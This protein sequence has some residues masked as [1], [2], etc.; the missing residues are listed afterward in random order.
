MRLNFYD[1]L[2]FLI[3]SYYKRNFGKKELPV[4]TSMIVLGATTFLQLIIL[5]LIA[6]LFYKNDQEYIFRTLGRSDVIFCVILFIAV[7]QLLYFCVNRRYRLII[8]RLRSKNAMYSNSLFYQ[9]LGLNL[10][11]LLL[12]FLLYRFI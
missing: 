10:F 11:F 3:F 1:K 2:F 9:Y 6:L 5:T 4:L 7:F 12:L 8:F